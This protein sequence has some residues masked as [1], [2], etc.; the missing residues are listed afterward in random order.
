MHNR[1]GILIPTMNRYNFIL[2]Q[3][4]FYKSVNCKHTIYIGDS[5]DEINAKLLQDKLVQYKNTL[6]ITYF[7]IPNLN[8][9]QA[10][11]FLAN[12]TIE[13]YC[14][15]IGDDDFFIPESLAK[16]AFFLK[17]NL[18]YRTAQGKAIIFYL[19]EIGPYG[20]IEQVGPYWNNCASEYESSIDRLNNF[21]KNYWVPQFSVHRTKEFII[22]SLAYSEIKDKSFGE[23]IH[24]FT[25]IGMGKSKFIDCMYL[26]RQGHQERYLLPGPYKWITNEDWFSSYINFIKQ[27]SKI[28]SHKENNLSTEICGEYANNIFEIYFIKHLRNKTKIIESHSNNSF[29]YFMITNAFNFFKRYYIFNYF[30]KKYRTKKNYNNFIKYLEPTTLKES[31]KLYN[32]IYGK[33][34]F[35]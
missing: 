11:T 19:K 10:I 29:I 23:L 9:R 32:I 16:C 4:D 8:D 2:R 20:K 34:S 28:I 18:N 1:V 27:I 17:N 26:I 35:N 13:D 7:Y 22:D 24:S 25:F 15:F 6:N 3:L 14:A 21:A 33:N 5:S 31:H 30:S 12:N